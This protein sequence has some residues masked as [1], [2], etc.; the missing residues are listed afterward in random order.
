MF[1]VKNFFLIQKYKRIK[2]QQKSFV[3]ILCS[4]HFFCVVHMV[5]TL[6][7]SQKAKKQCTFI[8]LK[9]FL[10]EKNSWIHKNSRSFYAGSPASCF[11]VS[12]PVVLFHCHE[13]TFLFFGTLIRTKFMDWFNYFPILEIYHQDLGS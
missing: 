4:S 2:T 5:F 13:S 3:I 9:Y 11:V 1:I 10:I 8:F 7:L 12:S 6:T